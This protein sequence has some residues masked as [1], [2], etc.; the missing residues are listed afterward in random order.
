MSLQYGC[1]RVGVAEKR[2]V[3]GGSSFFLPKSLQ[4][5]LSL[6]AFKI[7]AAGGAVFQP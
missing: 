5:Q 1:S 2:R 3:G 7:N 4:H 6:H